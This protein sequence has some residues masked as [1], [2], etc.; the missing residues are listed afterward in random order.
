MASHVHPS[1]GPAILV[2]D[3]SSY[4]QCLGSLVPISMTRDGFWSQMLKMLAI[5]TFWDTA[6]QPMCVSSILSLLC[7]DPNQ[8]RPS[9]KSVVVPHS[10]CHVYYEALETIDTG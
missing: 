2:F 7:K 3:F 8:L 5:R 6:R 4:A 10:C 9:V 1:I